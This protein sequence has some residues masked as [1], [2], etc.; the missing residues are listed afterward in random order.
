MHLR[1]C[2]RALPDSAFA[3]ESVI[4]REIL[5]E[6]DLAWATCDFVLPPEQQELVNPAGFSIGR[7]YFCPERFVPYLICKKDGG[8][9]VGFILLSEFIWNGREFTGW[10]YFI[11]P[12]HQKKGYGRDAAALAVRILSSA[13]PNLQIELSV[14]EGNLEAERLYLSVGF[15][16]TDRFDGDERV[17]IYS[18]KRNK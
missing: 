5:T 12:E 4:F 13:M 3:G 1:E 16:K 14:V 7:A 11:A 6:D 10:S 18:T 17:F 8:V 15:E 2:L 9:P